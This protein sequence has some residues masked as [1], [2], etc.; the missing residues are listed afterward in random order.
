MK[1]D[2]PTEPKQQIG[3]RLDPTLVIEAKV[4]A[5]RQRRRLN[6]VVE[7]ALRDL[8]KKHRAQSRA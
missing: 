4:L 1:R 6:E 7:E 2:T 8:L 3:V 5:A